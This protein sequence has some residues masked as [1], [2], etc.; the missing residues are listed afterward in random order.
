MAANRKNSN[1]IY[2]SDFASYLF[3]RRAWDLHLQGINGNNL[4]RLNKGTAYHERVGTKIFLTEIIKVMGILFI[5]C[6]LGWL[7]LLLMQNG[8]G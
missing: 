4:I 8:A 6:A 2:A 3:C 7:T 5:L 1:V